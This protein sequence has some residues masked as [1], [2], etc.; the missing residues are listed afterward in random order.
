MVYDIVFF[1]ALGEENQHL[2]DA[3]EAS[4]K[5]GKLPRDLRYYIGTETLQEFLSAH[6]DATLPNIIGNRLQKEYSLPFCR[7]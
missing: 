1:E 7:L 2:Y 6:P 4:K 3:L 5:A